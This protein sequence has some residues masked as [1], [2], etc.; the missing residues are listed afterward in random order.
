MKRRRFLKSAATVAVGFQIVPRHVLGQSQT[1]P[2]AK[3]N[4]AG[5]GIGGQRA[6]AL[7][8]VAAPVAVTY[9]KPSSC[10]ASGSALTLYNAALAPERGRRIVGANH[11]DPQDPTSALSALFC[12]AVNSTR[13]ALYRRYMAGWFEYHL[14][15]D[16]SYGPW[17]FN[18]PSGPLATDL[19]SNK[20]TYTEAAAPLAARR[21]VNFGTNASNTFC[22]STLFFM[23][24]DMGGTSAWHQVTK[25]LFG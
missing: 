11:T 18:Q 3:L 23:L 4:I 5:V 22:V 17:V 12:G 7:A 8:S 10:N 20:V 21:F 13:Q 14:R 25:E 9:S 1:P 6:A 24:L 15:A 19:G 16:A 2:S